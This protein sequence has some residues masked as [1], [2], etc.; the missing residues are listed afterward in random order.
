MSALLNLREEKAVE[1][2][3]SIG[4]AMACTLAGELCTLS[5]DEWQLPG[6]GAMETETD[7]K[8]VLADP[9]AMPRALEDILS[10]YAV[11]TSPIVRQSV[12]IWLLSLLRH[13]GKHPGIQVP[14]AGSE[15]T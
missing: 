15:K 13:G 8:I 9:E 1:L 11:G 6:S 2:Q 12:C 4:E 14:W 5:R 7:P 10:Q 3:F